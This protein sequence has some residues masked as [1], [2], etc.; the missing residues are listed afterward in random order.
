MLIIAIILSVVATITLGLLTMVNEPKSQTNRLFS[1]ANLFIALWIWSNFQAEQDLYGSLFWTRSAFMSAILAA[2]FLGGFVYFF[3]SVLHKSKV[4]LYGNF[5]S[6]LFLAILAATPYLVAGVDAGEGFSNVVT[7]SLYNIYALMFMIQVV[8]IVLVLRWKMHTD[9]EGRRSIKLLTTGLALSVAIAAIT[10]LLMPLISNNNDYATI[11][12]TATVIFSGFTFYA[13]RRH[14]LFDIR[15]TIAT[16]MAYVLSVGIL[17]V[18]VSLA[19]LFILNLS[20]SD[21]DFERTEIGYIVALVLVS[22]VIFGPI[23]NI[24]D[25]ITDKFFLRNSYDSKKAIN[26]LSSIAAREYEIDRLAEG[27]IDIIGDSLRPA[28]LTLILL[29][30]K[31]DIYE[32]YG[33]DCKNEVIKSMV[34]FI[35]FS[36]SLPKVVTSVQESLETDSNTSVPSSYLKDNDIAVNTFLIT[37]NNCVGII[38]LG[39]KLSGEPYYDKDIEFLT[40][41]ANEMAI[42][43]QNARRFDE[44]KRFNETLKLEIERATKELRISNQKLQDLDKAKDEFVS[45]ASHQLRTPLT[46]VKGFL[47][48]VLDGDAGKVAKQQ[49][50]LLESAYSSSQ[51]MVYLIADLLNVSRL[52]TGK[53]VITPGESHLPDVVESEINQLV[54]SAKMK[55][56]TINYKKPK[57]FPVLYLDETKT[58]QVMMN[59]IDNAIYYTPS[60]G[61]IDVSLHADDKKVEFRVKDNGIGV[62]KADQ[63]NLFTKFYRAENAKKARPD[64]TGLGIFMAKKV[65]VDQGGAIIFESKEGKGSTFG[66]SFP[67]TRVRPPKKLKN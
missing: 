3:P 11:G 26:M 47:S 20:S 64:G 61:K 16:A 45:M 58:R 60:G 5:F 14:S 7:G 67:L 18:L 27:A 21:I 41:A 2:T 6:G 32:L 42:A 35:R 25:R 33:H 38:L 24:F 54:D 39:P 56:I 63:K 46:S 53:F 37:Q 51:R 34:E 31:G 30:S 22:T 59:F 40:I 29:D 1:A 62:P 44:I 23:R 28:T 50:P 13:I 65:I 52:Q 66:F 9:S 57:K 55:S 8:S 19:S 12:T 17:L 49:K 36:K 4:Y 15:T 43:I 48:M 10:N